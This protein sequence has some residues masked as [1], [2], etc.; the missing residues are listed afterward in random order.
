M[1]HR[2]KPIGGSNPPLS[3]RIAGDPKKAA[4]QETSGVLS[5]SGPRGAPRAAADGQ[6]YAC[7]TLSPFI[8]ASASLNHTTSEI[9]EERADGLLPGAD[10]FLGRALD[11]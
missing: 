8:S 3:A 4:R 10:T 6:G 1:R 7:W 2:R 5:G 9:I 11:Q